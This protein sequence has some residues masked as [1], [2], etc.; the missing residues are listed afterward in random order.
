MSL[1]KRI[2][3]VMSVGFAS[4]LLARITKDIPILGS[5]WAWGWIGGI[6]ATVL[7]NDTNNQ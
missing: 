5:L 1:T 7:T 3:I 6:T 4:I 2:I